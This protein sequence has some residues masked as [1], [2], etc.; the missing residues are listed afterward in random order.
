[1]GHAIHCGNETIGFPRPFSSNV[2]KPWF[3]HSMLC[4]CWVKCKVEWMYTN[5]KWQLDFHNVNTSRVQNC[6]V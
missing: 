2:M 1:M 6:D 3:S 4:E 5:M